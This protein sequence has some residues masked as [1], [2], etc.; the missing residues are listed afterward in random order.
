MRVIPPA[1]RALALG[2]ALT[3]CA[4]N[5]PA[6]RTAAHPAA[7]ASVERP[8]ARPS[9][10][11][12]AAPARVTPA[13]VDDASLV[14]EEARVMVDGHEEVWRLRWHAAPATACFERD[15]WWTCP[16]RD[17]ERGQRGDA[18]LERLRDGAVIDSLPLAPDAR[19]DGDERAHESSSEVVL[20]LRELRVNVGSEEEDARRERDLADSDFEGRPVVPVITLRDYDRDGRATEFLVRA[21]TQACGYQPYAL[22]GLSRAHPWLHF[23][24]DADEPGAPARLLAGGWEALR[25][26]DAGLRQEFGCGF[27]GLDYAAYAR[28]RI[29]DGRVEMRSYYRACDPRGGER[30]PVRPLRFDDGPPAGRQRAPERSR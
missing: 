20:P 10:T 15:D 19:V 30:G 23:F 16:C 26:G 6:R 14:R 2:A 22:V 27:H 11:A 25:T 3:A 7:V 29:V 4:S 12:T 5:A 13:A 17:V 24:R 18:T 1:R 9:P 28:T 8:A 21:E